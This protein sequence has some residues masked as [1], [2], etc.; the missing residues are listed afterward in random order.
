MAHLFEVQLAPNVIVSAPVVAPE[1]TSPLYTATKGAA[2]DVEPICTHVIPPP[3]IPEMVGVPFDLAVTVTRY[4]RLFWNATELVVW[5]ETV[6]SLEP[7][8]LFVAMIA[9]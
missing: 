9:T 6:E 5:L 7:E 8:S 1:V 2:V 3:V 4:R